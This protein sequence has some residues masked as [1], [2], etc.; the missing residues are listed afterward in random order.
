MRKKV[1]NERTLPVVKSNE[2]IQNS[3]YN[4]TVRQQK[5]LSY[6]IAKINPE[7]KELG[8]IEVRISDF[9]ELCG[10]DKNHFYNEIKEIVDNL[11][12]KSI[13]IDTPEKIFKFRF[14][15]EFEIIPRAGMVRI[16]LNSNLKRYLIDLSGKFTKYELWTILNLHGKYS[17]RLYELF[18]SYAYQREKTFDIDELR[19]LLLAEHYKDF[20]AFRRRVIE[21]SIEEINKYSDIN[22][23]YEK[24]TTGRTV[25]ALKIIIEKKDSWDTYLTYREVDRNLKIK[26]GENPDQ[27][28]VFDKTY[29]DFTNTPPLSDDS[30]A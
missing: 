17:I 8:F 28:S 20:R 7:D 2:L 25:S 15:S 18:K 10:I 19:K 24:I 4:L 12:S 1:T 3:I 13:W 23:R 5:L 9:C 29:T 11:D 27:L 16:L 26:S 6:V 30:D 21:P 14:F 22:V